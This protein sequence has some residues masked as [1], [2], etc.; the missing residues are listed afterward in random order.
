[1]GGLAA[2]AIAKVQRYRQ[3]ATAL[4][5]YQSVLT[6]PLSQSLLNLLDALCAEDST[7]CLTAY[8][9]WFHVQAAHQQTWQDHLIQ[10]IL[11]SDNPFT[12]Q[13]QRQ[14]LADLPESLIRAA[15]HDLRRL[16]ILY[17]CDG[18]N[19]SRWV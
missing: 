15:N 9:D 1:M 6:T 14:N 2:K 8:G 5:L 4:L 16:Q 10:Q 11:R 17:T 18:E 19:L 13:A 12:R 3:Q 7:R